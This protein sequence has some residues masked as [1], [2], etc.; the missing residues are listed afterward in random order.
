MF[1]K[2]RE[3]KLEA[4]VG[5]NSSFRGD[6]TVKGTLRIDGSLEGNIVTDYL[7]LGEK[8][9][10]KGNVTAKGITVGGRIE[11]SLRATEIL[12]ITP[13]GSAFG[14]IFTERL[15]VAE[16]ASYNGRISMGKSDTNVVE[17][18]AKDN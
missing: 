4:L 10:V 15:A 8:A 14:D 16:G 11:G 17:F 7:V 1:N 13:H 12:E 3:N 6:I 18:Q 2:S 5:E 9:N